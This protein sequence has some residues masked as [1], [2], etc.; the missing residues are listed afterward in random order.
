MQGFVVDVRQ[1]IR[2]FAREPG[3]TAVAVVA[4]AIGVGSSTAMFSVVDAALVRPLP[5]V[6]SVDGPG[7]RVP[8][9]AAEFFA[10]AKNAKTVEAIGT[11]YPHA[12]TFASATGPTQLRIAN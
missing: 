3:F 5:Y 10:L 4:L 6:V 2:G 12:G 1:S 11:F 8:V 7:Q 9:G